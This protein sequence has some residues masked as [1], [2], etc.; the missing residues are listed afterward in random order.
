[1]R[2]CFRAQLTFNAKYIITE[3]IKFLVKANL[4]KG[5]LRFVAANSTEQHV[6]NSNKIVY[7]FIFL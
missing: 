7:L 3:F 6:R 4:V 2:E 1:M 5:I